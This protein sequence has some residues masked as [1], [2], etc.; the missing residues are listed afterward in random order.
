MGRIVQIFF[1]AG[2]EL[3]AGSQFVQDKTYNEQK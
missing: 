1:T 3:R 2:F